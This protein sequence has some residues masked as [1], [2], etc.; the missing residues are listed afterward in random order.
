MQMA[1]RIPVFL[2][3][4]LELPPNSALQED[5]N[6]YAAYVKNHESE[7]AK[8]LTLIHSAKDID[9]RHFFLES[10]IS[11]GMHKSLAE[12]SWRLPEKDARG[13]QSVET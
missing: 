11:K 2:Q 8:W 7:V 13:L 9:F 4:K 10:I 5:R 3:S 12:L 1:A 6:A